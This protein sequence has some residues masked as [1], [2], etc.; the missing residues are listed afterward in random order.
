MST[1]VANYIFMHIF[2][3]ILLHIF[4][5]QADREVTKK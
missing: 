1:S 5:S 4:I 3:N 2:V